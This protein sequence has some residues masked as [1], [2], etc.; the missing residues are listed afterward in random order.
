MT[1]GEAYKKYQSLHRR[2][3]VGDPTV[4]ESDVHG[5]Y[6]TYCSVHNGEG[7]GK[8]TYSAYSLSHANRQRERQ[9]YPV[10][11][12]GEM[13]IFGRIWPKGY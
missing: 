5:A 11:G 3:E 13:T 10:Y 4:S 7:S 9:P 12:I 2:F 8:L 6:S 1:S